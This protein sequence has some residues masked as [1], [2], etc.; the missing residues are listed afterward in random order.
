MAHKYTLS[1]VALS[2][3][4]KKTTSV[5]ES[6]VERLNLN[7]I[8]KLFK[9]PLGDIKSNRRSTS[10]IERRIIIRLISSGMKLKD[11]KEIVG[12][13][14]GSICEW[15]EYKDGYKKIKTHIHRYVM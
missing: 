8:K 3:W 1:R 7:E 11:A 9:W 15:S 6:D 14:S 4:F 12:I 2:I 5:N 10:H 13:T